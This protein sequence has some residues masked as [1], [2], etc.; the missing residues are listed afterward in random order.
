F[1]RFEHPPVFH[2]EEDTN[3][4]ELRRDCRRPPVSRDDPGI[5][6]EE[7]PLIRNHYYVN[8]ASPVNIS[9]HGVVVKEKRYT[10]SKGTIAAFFFK[11]DISGKNSSGCPAL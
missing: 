11:T 9:G 4:D 3:M 1:K 5:K 6:V 7:E 10:N 8:T 2:R